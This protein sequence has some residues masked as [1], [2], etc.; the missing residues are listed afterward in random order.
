MPRKN[1][2]CVLTTVRFDGNDT[3]YKKKQEKMLKRRK[4]L[5]TKQ[6]KMNN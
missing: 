1:V 2:C 5:R 4:N 3:K 6:N